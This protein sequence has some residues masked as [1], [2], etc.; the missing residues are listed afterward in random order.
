MKMKHVLL[1]V[2]ISAF[3]VLFYENIMA[4]STGITG[5]TQK[6]GS[7]P[8]CTCH[9][10]SPNTAV[11][12]RIIGPSSMRAGDTATFMLKIKGGP[13]LAAGC[14]IS[15]SAGNLILS[16]S[17][18]FLRRALEGSSYELTHNSPKT[19]TPDTVTFTFRYIA[20]N[21]PN[22]T[23]TLYANGNS[24]NLSGG[25]G[26][27]SWNYATNASISITVNSIRNIN[28][29]AT[30]YSLSQN[31]PNPFNPETNIKYGLKQSGFVSLKVYDLAGK[32]V[33][34]LV[35]QN[36]NAGT[37]VIDFKASDYNLT[38]GI[39]FYKL[40]TGDFSEVRKMILTK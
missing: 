23:V 14:D 21:T 8:G 35:N 33:A 5:V 9:N 25:T 11:S 3:A 22:S 37:Y 13:L 27:D 31:Y 34:T 30:K 32:E 40:N 24:V 16:S 26:G 2:V 1:A 17:E 18:T 38:S 20:P 28:E 15:S 39:Y 19:P 6:P 36:Q 7:T 4:Y 10:P 29:V 12:V